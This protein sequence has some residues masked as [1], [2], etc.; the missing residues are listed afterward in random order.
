[1]CSRILLSSVGYFC[2]AEIAESATNKPAKRAS[3]AQAKD[4]KRPKPQDK[5]AKSQQL[6]HEFNRH[7]EMIMLQSNKQS[8]SHDTYADIR[9]P[10]QEASELS[11]R[12]VRQHA[13]LA[14]ERPHSRAQPQPIGE[15]FNELQ[16]WS[17]QPSLALAQCL[18]HAGA[19]QVSRGVAEHEA[20][21]A[22]RELVQLHSRADELL[23]HFWSSH[24][25]NHDKMLRMC[26]AI[27]RL[28]RNVPPS[29]TQLHERLRVAQQAFQNVQ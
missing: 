3:D 28:V 20:R 27:E 16:K 7:S 13:M 9:R 25:H 12:G 6:I 1:M 4:A 15:Q 22:S 14:I 2:F 11:E 8:K 18:T 19:L 24:P 26:S 23:R 21:P 5:S 10:E 17:A 29:M